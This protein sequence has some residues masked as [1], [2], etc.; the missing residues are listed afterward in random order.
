MVHSK[1]ASISTS[2]WPIYP[3]N[4]LV[5]T[6][7]IATCVCYL[8]FLGGMRENRCMLISF[9]ILL[10]I[11][12]L[13]ELAMAIIFFVFSRKVHTYLENDLMVSLRIYRDSSPE[14]NQTIKQDFDAVQHWFRCCGVHGLED[15]GNDIPISCCTRD[16]CDASVISN[17]QEG[18]LVKLRDWFSWNYKCTGAGVV[19]MFIIQFICLCVTIP[20]FCHLGRQGLGYK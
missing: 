1:F 9:F 13:I 2:F 12:M 3:A 16:P 4:T 10:F 18:C 7:T 17:W 19:T 15:W 11:L 14:G 20:V 8:G 5:V 6:G